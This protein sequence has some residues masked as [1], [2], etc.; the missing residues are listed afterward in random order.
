MLESLCMLAA[1]LLL[2]AAFAL[3]ALSQDRH[4]EAVAERPGPTPV[5]RGWHRGIASTCI[6]ATLPLCWF[7]AG[8]GMGTL[9]WSFLCF[10]AAFAVSL[11]LTWRPGALLPF[12]TPSGPRE[13]EH[14]TRHAG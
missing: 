14:S 7:T 1:G 12:T 9:L 10:A 5:R 2:V 8:G 3:L 4:W 13:T 6:T 11:T